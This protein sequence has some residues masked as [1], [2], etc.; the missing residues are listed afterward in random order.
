MNKLILFILQNAYRSE[1]HQFKNEN[2]WHRELEKSHT[3]RRLK[4]MIPEGAEYRIIN[5]SGYIGDN[6]DSSYV[7]DIEYMN[8]FINEI[9]PNV[10]CACGKIAQSGCEKLGL[11]FI[12]APHPAWR[13]LSKQCSNEI[14]EKIK[15]NLEL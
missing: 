7:A 15:Q 13:Q 5:S 12:P 6:P 9:K 10:I 1:K 11:N 14:K 8:K 2:E 4:E 3:G